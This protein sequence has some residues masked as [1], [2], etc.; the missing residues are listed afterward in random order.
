MITLANK[1]KKLYLSLILYTWKSPFKN[2]Y[3]Q[4]KVFQIFINK[5]PLT[6]Q[7]PS[8]PPYIL[9]INFFQFSLFDTIV[10][11]FPM[12]GFDSLYKIASRQIG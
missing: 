10:L 5:L 1:C 12:V 4:G 2:P 9:L 6:Y 8:L 3:N 11:Q 7:L